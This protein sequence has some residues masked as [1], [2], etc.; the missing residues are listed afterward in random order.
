MLDWAMLEAMREVDDMTP[1][2]P[3]LTPPPDGY[4][5]MRAMNAAIAISQAVQ[6]RTANQRRPVDWHALA[7]YR[8]V[9]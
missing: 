9:S 6:A 8:P 5:S 7:N 2:S 1:G 3:P 4:D